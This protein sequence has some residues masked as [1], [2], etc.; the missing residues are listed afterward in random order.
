M[1]F[2]CKNV[3]D[4]ANSKVFFTF[5]IVKFGNSGRDL[6]LFTLHCTS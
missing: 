1:N 2:I 6:K 5:S 4:S 3:D